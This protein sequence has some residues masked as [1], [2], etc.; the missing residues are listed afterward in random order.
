MSSLLRPTSPDYDME[1]DV[2]S[3]EFQKREEQLSLLPSNQSDHILESLEKDD[4]FDMG[5]DGSSCEE[6][7]AFSYNSLIMMA[8]RNSPDNKLTLSGIYDYI[9][10]HYPFYKRHKPGWQ[11]SIRHNLSLNKCF[12]K[13][14]RPYDDP[15]K[16]NYWTLSPECDDMFIGSPGG[17]LRKRSR[18]RKPKAL[19]KYA[20][21]ETMNHLGTEDSFTPLGSHRSLATSQTLL[22]IIGL[23]PQTLESTNHNLSKGKSFSMEAL[24]SPATQHSLVPQL[25]IAHPQTPLVPQIS[26]NPGMYIP[27]IQM[28]SHYPVSLIACQPGQD[29]PIS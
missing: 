21:C 20:S 27:N 8:I 2:D 7:P 5:V 29:E 9:S 12:I 13:I 4:V 15:G 25:I 23:Q 22:P 10:T 24:L 3:L 19:R 26:L 17:K 6:K 11:N 16:G 28:L 18:S 14:P 1:V